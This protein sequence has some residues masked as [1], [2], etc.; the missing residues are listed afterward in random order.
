MRESA[1]LDAINGETRRGDWAGLI[2]LIIAVAHAVFYFA[3][4]LYLPFDLEEMFLLGYAL[5]LA[6][7]CLVV[8]LGIKLL[9]QLRTQYRAVM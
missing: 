4:S 6:D 7:S 8:F 2:I 9:A 3:P 1:S 5:V